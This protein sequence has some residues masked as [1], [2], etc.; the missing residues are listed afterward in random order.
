MNNK[1]LLKQH[2]PAAAGIDGNLR[3]EISIDHASIMQMDQRLHVMWR[4]MA[5]K[6]QDDR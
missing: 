5:R 3:L 6:F 4:N 2:Q 1:M